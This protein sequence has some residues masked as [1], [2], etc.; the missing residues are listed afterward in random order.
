[1]HITIQI[2]WWISIILRLLSNILQNDMTP[3]VTQ[4]AQTQTNKK[5]QLKKGSIP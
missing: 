4:G 3:T 2:L 5:T 1:M